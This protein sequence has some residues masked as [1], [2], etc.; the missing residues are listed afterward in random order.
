MI[1][2]CRYLHNQNHVQATS[3]GP[4]H[5]A[6]WGASCYPEFFLNLRLQAGG[7]PRF[8]QGVSFAI[9]QNPLSR[10]GDTAANTGVL[11]IMD[12]YYPDVRPKLGRKLLCCSIGV[13]RHCRLIFL[14]ASRE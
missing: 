9:I 14:C 12:Y 2:E 7:I 11:A 5:A 4:V 10:F 13:V 6:G 3:A 1:W 8:Y